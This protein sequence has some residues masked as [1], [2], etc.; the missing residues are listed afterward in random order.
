MFRSREDYTC[1][2]VR[3]CTA[4]IN[5]A[6]L[7]KAELFETESNQSFSTKHFI[8]VSEGSWGRG[9]AFVSVLGNLKVFAFCLGV[10]YVFK[11]GHEI[12]VKKWDSRNSSISVVLAPLGTCLPCLQTRRCNMR[13]SSKLNKIEFVLPQELVCSCC[14][15][16]IWLLATVGCPQQLPSL[17]LRP[18]IQSGC[19]YCATELVHV[20]LWWGLQTSK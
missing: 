9:W 20:N 4:Q 18:H 8:A 3:G 10:K 14:Q 15:A 11:C 2:S 6:A 1:N 19:R 5:P 16:C 12:C 17:C 13:L 7:I